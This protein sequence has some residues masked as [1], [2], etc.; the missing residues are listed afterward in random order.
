MVSPACLS[1]VWQRATPGELHP[2]SQCR[3]DTLP[4]LCR[5]ILSRGKIESC[6]NRVARSPMLFYA[7]LSGLLI[8]V[9]MR[10]LSRD[11][12]K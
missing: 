2:H 6:M 12:A 7:V 10:S 11:K 8:W 9:S 3:G 1:L 5:E 4:A